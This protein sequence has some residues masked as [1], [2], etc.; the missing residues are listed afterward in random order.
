VSQTQYSEPEHNT[1]FRG[2]H[3]RFIGGRMLLAKSNGICA[4]DVLAQGFQ[5]DEAL[6]IVERAEDTFNR[7]DIDAILSRYADDVVVRF[8]G[9]R[10]IRGKTAAETFLRARFARQKNYKLK[11]TLFMVDGFKIGATYTASRKD[12]KTGNRCSVA[13]LSSGNIATASGPMGRR[14]EC[15]GSGRRQPHCDKSTICLDHNHEGMGS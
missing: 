4:M 8:A 15:L 9:I 10:E 12:A 3:L 11:K 6:K 2:L 7:G 13:A 1:Q 5:W 14:Y